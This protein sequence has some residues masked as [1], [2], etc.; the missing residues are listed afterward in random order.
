MTRYLR[1]LLFAAGAL[2]LSLMLP[3][4]TKSPSC[5][6]AV[7]SLEARLS[8]AEMAWNKMDW[9]CR[10]SIVTLTRAMRS[11]AIDSPEVGVK[12]RDLRARAPEL[13]EW[14]SALKSALQGCGPEILQIR[15]TLE[16]ETA[17]GAIAIDEA[18][19]LGER[20]TA[21]ATQMLLLAA[22]GE[23]TSAARA[24]IASA[25]EQCS[26]STTGLQSKDQALQAI[27]AMQDLLLA[28]P[29]PDSW[30]KPLQ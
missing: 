30:R 27:V 2:A 23:S 19:A 1:I 8:E 25:V 13:A 10:E 15:E 18:K 17:R 6:D 4:C 3:N 24:K 21:T 29:T 9:W 22:L 16:M 11:A 14:E 7:S 12:V 26:L 5:E 20:L 28:T